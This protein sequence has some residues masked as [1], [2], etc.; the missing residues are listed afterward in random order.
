MQNLAGK[1]DCDKYIREE[2]ERAG[3]PVIVHKAE[4]GEVPYSLIG[5]IETI[6]GKITF[7][8]AWRYWVLKGLIPLAVAQK[9]YTHPEGKFS[10]RAGGHCGALPPESQCSYFDDQGR[11]LIKK[12]DLEKLGIDSPLYKEI[13]EKNIYS[14]VDD[15]KTEGHGFVE[16]YHIDEQA[17]LLLFMMLIKN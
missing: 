5:E 15:P 7:T 16:M 11:P 12:F 14:F 1:V 6:Y 13:V 10:V 3:I 17:G 8:R 4:H 9:I 2:L